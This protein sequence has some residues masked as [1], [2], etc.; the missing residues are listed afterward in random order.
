MMI[1]NFPQ[2]FG[3]YFGTLLQDWCIKRGWVLVWSLGANAPFNPKSHHPTGDVQFASNN[4]V[5]DARVFPQTA[6][7]K[8]I[9]SADL[10]AATT[11]FAAQ[12][13]KV[14]NTLSNDSH[15]NVDPA[16]WAKW[17]GAMAAGLPRSSA[18]AAP[19]PGDCSDRSACV[20][21][22]SGGH[23]VCYQR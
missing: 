17:W 15:V 13:R 1:A 4:R 11:V 9:S 19:R 7:S 18:V 6:A 3:T 10:A 2:L 20:G 21:V 16:Q 12:W 14:N 22:G 23:C 5:L 8:N